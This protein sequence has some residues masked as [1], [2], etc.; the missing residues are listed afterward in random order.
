M[1]KPLERNQSNLEQGANR[2][3]GT[4]EFHK[5][6]QTA[7]KT[8]ENSRETR[9]IENREHTTRKELETF[10]TSSRPLGETREFENK[11]RL[12]ALQQLNAQ[13][14]ALASEE[15]DLRAKMHPDVN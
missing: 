13:V 5:K 7:Q 1:S 3:K 8:L 14:D 12:L 11:Q 15:A 6:E 9:E 4:R 2:S 10:R